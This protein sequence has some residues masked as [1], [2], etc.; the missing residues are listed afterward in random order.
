MKA[1]CLDHL[2][3]PEVLVLRDV[4]LP[5]LTPG[6]AL[7]RMRS[8]G[9]NYADIYRRRGIFQLTGAPPFVLGYEGAG[10]IE[11]LLPSPGAAVAH[12]FREGDRVAFADVARANAEVVLAPLDRLVPLP[13]RTPFEAAAAVML[14]GLTAQYL[15]RDSHPLRAGETALIH[16]AAGGVGLLLIQVC[17]LKGARAL[18]LTSSA[19]KKLAAQQAGADAV[20]LSGSDWVAW[21]QAEAAG[22]VDVVYDSVGVTLGDS[23]RAARVG[24]RVVFY[25]MSGGD[26]AP[27]NPRLLMDQSKTLTGGDLWNVLTSHRE[28]LERCAELFGWMES[29]KVSA[30]VA[31]T[32]PLGEGAAAHAFLEGRQSIGKVL[33]QP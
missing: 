3:G 15:T 16:A 24:G 2:G 13:E 11:A 1:L 14:Q 17:K 22:G 32:F 28:R 19:E 31:K 21:S 25:G 30:R 8:I 10:V 9:L 5:V 12:R 23:L 6:T 26:P 18:G 20:A 4:P 33:L 29:G 7:V 27:V